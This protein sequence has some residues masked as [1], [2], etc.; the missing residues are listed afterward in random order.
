MIGLSVPE[1]LS[2]VGA[3][4]VPISDFITP[5]LSSV[6]VDLLG[7]GKKRATSILMDMIQGKQ[8]RKKEM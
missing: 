5:S 1:D 7:I 4:D 8:I 3:D 2:V 6:H